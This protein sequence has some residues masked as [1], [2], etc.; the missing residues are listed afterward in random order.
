VIG[1]GLDPQEFKDY[2][3]QIKEGGGSNVDNWEFDEL[4]KVNNIF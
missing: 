1:R 2:L 4:K 3:D